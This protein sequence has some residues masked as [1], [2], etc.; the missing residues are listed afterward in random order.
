MFVNRRNKKRSIVLLAAAAVVCGAFAIIPI[1]VALASST[2][3]KFLLKAVEGAPAVVEVTSNFRLSQGEQAV[4]KPS[5]SGDWTSAGLVEPKVELLPSTDGLYQ[6]E[7]LSPEGSGWALTATATGEMS[8]NYR[9]HFEDVNRARSVSEAPGGHA[10]PLAISQQGLEVL[11]GSDVLICPRRQSDL[12]LISDVFQV[13]VSLR[14]GQKALAPWEPLGKGGASFKVTGKMQLLENYIAWGDLELQTLRQS[15]PSV[16]VGFSRDYE[17]LSATQRSAYGKTLM[18]LLDNLK[19]TLS[20]R[21]DLERLSIVTCGMSGFAL[22]QPAYSTLLDSTV[23]C[24]KGGEL[25]G[26]GAAAAAGGLFQLWNGWSLVPAAGGEAEWFQAGL[27]LFYPMRVA[28]LTGLMDSSAAYK[29]F[30]ESYRDYL[31]DPRS[32]TTSLVQAAGNSADRAFLAEKGAALCASLSKKLQDEAKGSSKNIEWL[33]GQMTS[34]FN[35]LKGRDYTLVDLSE[36]LENATGR[37]WDRYFNS[38]VRGTV[39]ILSSEFSETGLFGNTG[40]GRTLVVGKNSGKSWIYV[41]VA[42]VIILLVPI[43]FSPYI[44]RAVKLD[45]TMPKILP[46]DDDD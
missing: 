18:M 31:A 21:P 5:T 46:D 45:L 8:V 23:I 7:A 29:D 11:K 25:K 32:Q 41:V 39:A 4:L 3:V 24:D 35:H 19:S 38:R 26:E 1:H 44:R 28:A 13:D 10:P 6:V 22:K 30:S 27:S 43:I 40:F 16:V 20:A 37:S 9:V 42:M 33:L 17:G 36:I 14:S 15:K 34:K 12:S 2:T